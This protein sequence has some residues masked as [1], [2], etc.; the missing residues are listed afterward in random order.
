M[1]NRNSCSLCGGTDHNKRTCTGMFK[2]QDEVVTTCE[3]SWVQASPWG[4]SFRSEKGVRLFRIFL[5]FDYLLSI[6]PLP[7][8]H[9]TPFNPIIFVIMAPAT[10]S[11]SNESLLERLSC[12]IFITNFPPLVSAKDLWSTCSQY[13][14]VM[15]VFI[16]LKLSKL[17]KRFAFARF[18][19]VSNVDLLI[20]NLRSVWLGSFHLFANVA[21]FNREHSSGPSRKASTFFPSTAKNS[22]ASKPSFASILKD[23]VLRKCHEEP[24]MVLERGVLNFDGDSVLMGCVKEFQSSPNIHIAF[25]N[26]GFQDGAS[27]KSSKMNLN[28]MDGNDAE[29]V[30]D[31]YQHHDVNACDG[32]RNTTP[33]NEPSSGPHEKVPSFFGDSFGLE[34]L[35]SKH[36]IKQDVVLP[37]KVL[38]DPVFPPGFTPLKFVNNSTGKQQE[39]I[40]P[41]LILS[42]KEASN[43]VP[44]EGSKVSKSHHSSLNGSF[45]D[46][47]DSKETKLAHIT[48][49]AVKALWG[50][51]LFDFASIPSR[52]RSGGILCVWDKSLFKRRR[53]FSNEHYLCVER[54]W[55]PSKSNLLFISVY[56]PQALPLK[57][58]LWTFFTDTIHQWSGEVV[59]M[60][61]FNEVRYVSERFGSVFHAPNAAK[62]NAFIV[63][64][65]MHD[66]P[67]GGYSFTWSEKYATKMSKL[68]CFLV[69]Q[70]FLDLFPNIFGLILYRNISDHRPIL[71]KE[72]Q[73][74]YGPTPF[75]LFHSW[76]LEDDFLS[77]E[78]LHGIDLR[79]DQGMGLSDDGLNR[80]R[81]VRELD[82]LNKKEFI[83]LAQKAKVKWAIERDENLKFYHGIVN[84][85]RRFA[86]PD[87]DRVPL[88][89]QFPRVLSPDL[90]RS[91]E[92]MDFFKKYWSIVGND[93][94]LAVKEFFSTGFILNGCNPSCIA[95]I[96][97]VLDAKLLN[98]F[99]PISLVGC[100]YKIIG[101]ILANR[102]SY[103]IDDLI[104]QEQS[105]FVKGGQIIEGPV[106]LNE[107]ISWCKT[108]KEKALLFKVDF[109]KAFDSVRCDHLDDILDKF[110]FGQAGLRQGDPL[111]P[112]LFI[113]VMKSLQVSFQRLIDRGA[114]I[115]DKKITWVAWRQVM[116]KKQQW[117]LGVHSM[118]T[119]N[120]ALL[121]KWIWRFKSSHFGI[122][123]NVIKAIHR[124]EG[125]LN[126]LPL[127][128]GGSV[129]LSIIHAIEKLKSKGDVPGQALR[130]LNLATLCPLFH[131]LPYQILGT[132]GFDALWLWTFTTFSAVGGICIV[133]SL[134]TSWLGKSLNCNWV[135][136]L[137]D[138]LNAI[139]M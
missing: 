128:H 89:D 52:G 14:T 93:V 31:S 105:A 46:H 18:R 29:V 24:V 61:D 88:V 125:S 129:W 47:T 96:P 70:G 21:R 60:G 63:N 92:E 66:I 95:L 22:N 109:Q 74:D 32:N 71:L 83:D 123:I 102:L 118:F 13:G 41:S 48:D 84:K 39:A 86:Q 64:S 124:N 120:H 137:K 85:K 45:Q 107:V 43:I 53:V 12:N 19:K 28:W 6:L 38:S 117:G 5:V 17:G 57:R 111:S 135:E 23:P 78:S 65:H 91:L 112:F 25:L 56:S 44:D 10:Q 99:R 4:F 80:A 97:K 87:W 20:K 30:Q 72:S 100:Q 90:S 15:D 101:K 116:A 11:L 34:D 58:A 55:L 82:N 139:S 37:E 133:L 138:P 42:R 49:F 40:N 50:N 94:I 62:F 27:V 79:L 75:R 76:F 131:R 126:S 67:L 1:R 33:S 77:V 3:R 115:G 73:V 8:H 127:Y 69:S 134:M 110:G 35:I 36:P 104:S 59:V 2:D 81:L 103:V 114:D 113:L 132:Y 136:W 108:K 119:L 16:P 98:D 106:I 26:E 130:S 51:M 9:R 122:W 121:F 7:S 68:D 54:S